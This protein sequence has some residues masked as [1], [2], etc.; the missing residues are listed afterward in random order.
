MVSLGCRYFLCTYS[1]MPEKSLP[2]SGLGASLWPARHGL[3][4]LWSNRYTCPLPGFC[5]STGGG[6]CRAQVQTTLPTPGYSQ[7]S[8]SGRLLA[9]LRPSLHKCPQWS[10]PPRRVRHHFS[11]VLAEGRSLKMHRTCRELPCAGTRATSTG[12]QSA[13]HLQLGLWC[14]LQVMSEHTRASLQSFSFQ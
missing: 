13:R 1:A 9:S 12:F 2:R 5:R 7:R 6:A 3:K 14:L 11:S 10:D 8:A 4:G